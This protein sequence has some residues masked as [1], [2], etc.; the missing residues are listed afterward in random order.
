MNR[1]SDM[2]VMLHAANLGANDDVALREGANL[3][4]LW[5]AGYLGATIANQGLGHYLSVDCGMG[6]HEL[7][8]VPANWDGDQTRCPLFYRDVPSWNAYFVTPDGDT[9][10]EEEIDT[11]RGEPLKVVK[12]F[13]EVVG[14]AMA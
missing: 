4:T 12:R 11:H 13:D 8:L 10:W 5:L 6:S 9:V 1:Y 14:R 2:A 7:Q 3:T